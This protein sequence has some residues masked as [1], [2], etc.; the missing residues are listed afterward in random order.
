MKP[1][2]KVKQRR[3]FAAMSPELQKQIASK[4]GK[5]V[6]PEGRAFSVNRA[7]AKTAGEKGGAAKRSE[8]R[9]ADDVES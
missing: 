9:A 8:K 3:G 5:N 2:E 6:P 7:L 4:G 1:P